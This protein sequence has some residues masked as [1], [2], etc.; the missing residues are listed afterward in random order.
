MVNLFFWLTI[1]AA[2]AVWVVFLVRPKLK[3][4]PGFHVAALGVAAALYAVTAVLSWR[5][6]APP[7]GLHFKLY[8][9]VL[10][11]ALAWAPYLFYLAGICIKA[12]GA[13]AEDAE[14]SEDGR[15]ADAARLLESGH[16]SHARSIVAEALR[17]D[18]DNP[19]AHALMAEIHRARGKSDLALGSLRLVEANA[20]DNAQFAKA[21]FKASVI[22]DEDLGR[23]AD[24]ARELDLI[25]KRMPGAPEAAKAQALIVR[26]MDEAASQ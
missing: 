26:L 5:L 8:V 12:L 24:A 14:T 7:S 1:A 6:E 10:V 13:A 4:E 15:L 21:V 23:P 25:R 18:P 9:R 22:L 16:A 2:G 3:A 11:G 19:E 20:R 17:R